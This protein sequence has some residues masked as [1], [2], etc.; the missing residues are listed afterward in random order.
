MVLKKRIIGLPQTTATTNS[1]SPIAWGTSSMLP[2]DTAIS[3]LPKPATPA[4]V[5]NPASLTPWTTVKAFSDNIAKPIIEAPKSVTPPVTTTQTREAIGQNVDG[6]FIYAQDKPTTTTPTGTTATSETPTTQ[7]ITSPKPE[8]SWSLYDPNNYLWSGKTKDQFT[9]MSID[10]QTNLINQAVQNVAERQAVLDQVKTYA[11]NKAKTEYQTKQNTINTNIQASQ[12]EVAQI[13]ASQRIRE[14]QTNLDNL[15]QNLGF[16]G[17]WGRP[18]KSATAI[19]WASRML[20]QSEQTFQELKNIESEYQKMR[21]S[22]VEFNANA[23]EEQMRWLQKQL[24]DSVDASIIQAMQWFDSEA[25]LASIDSP[26]KLFDLQQKYL[27]MVDT[28]VEWITNRQVNEMKNLQTRY[29]DYAKQYAEDLKQQKEQQAEFTKNKN[30]LN[31][32]MSKAVGYYVDWNGSPLQTTDWKVIEY[33]DEADKPIIDWNTWKVAYF[34]TDANGN[35]VVEV[36]QLFTPEQKSP[37]I[38]KV[39][40]WADGQDI[41][42]YYD[43]STG[44]V[45]TVSTPTM[46]GW[47]WDLRGLASQFPWQARAKNN[48]PAGITWNANFDNP[49]PWTTA[50]A[51]QQAGVNYEKG[52]PRPWNEWGNYVTFPTMEDWLAAQRIMMT[53]TYGNTTVGNMLAKWVWTGEWP[54]YAQ[55]VA[56]MA[57]V[58]VNATVN[59]LSDEQL[60]TLQM[61]KIQKESPWLAKILQQQTQWQDN[62][63]TMQ[64]QALVS[65]IWGTKEERADLVSNIVKIA[66]S[67]WITVQ[68]AKAKLWLRS[69]T[70]DDFINVRTKDRDKTQ[71]AGKALTQVK[72]AIQALNNPN[73]TTDLIGIVWLLKSIDPTSVA[74]SDEVQNVKK[75]AWVLEAAQTQLKSW[76]SGDLLSPKQ[77][78]QLQEAMQTIVD[79]YDRKTS[80]DRN[81]IVKDFDKRWIDPNIIF[82][83]NDI[84]WSRS[85]IANDLALQAWGATQATNTNSSNPYSQY[86]KR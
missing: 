73:P 41:Y 21:E 15:K 80:T 79:A 43:Q 7:T 63:L 69:K 51:L 48:N 33:K 70:D 52:T 58:D 1:G 14:A 35:Q 56:W 9:A 49:K 34:N 5:T 32:N 45:K 59:Q 6:S 23:F 72:W 39:W 28:S 57:G 76:K 75:A 37:N 84:E 31:E 78:V 17:T 44:G 60:Q 54:R 26:K 36:K 82:W 46:T 81:Q 86:Q 19:E 68:E 20:I 55:Q 62:N 13:Q 65:W 38:Q 85:W 4:S 18:M 66:Q 42:G 29:A 12:N 8:F 24:T 3:K 74:R 47:L 77:R 53:Q 2:T 22:G 50:Y 25:A 61:A 27:D 64:A 40:V 11:E 67:E 83:T 30:T 16:L 10:D 71:E